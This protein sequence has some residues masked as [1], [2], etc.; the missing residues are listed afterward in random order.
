MARVFSFLSVLA[1]LGVLFVL[2]SCSSSGGS[3]YVST[4]G[5][6]AN[7]GLSPSKPVRTLVKAVRVA[8]T[9]DKAV[10][11]VIKVSG[12]LYTPGNGLSNA[13]VGLVINRPNVIISG[14]WNSDFTS[15]IGKSEFDGN[16]SLYHIIK[17]ENVTNVILKNLVIRGGNA[18][19]SNP[20]DG[21]GGVY[22]NNVRYLTIE[23]NVIISDNS[24]NFGGGLLLYVSANNAIS[25]NVYSNSAVYNGGGLYL[26]YSTNN[27]VN[28]S[29]YNNSAS[30][31]GGG[32]F[33]DSST[34]NT[35]SGSVYGNTANYGGG[36]YLY[37]SD[38]FTN[39]GW[40]TNNHANVSGG[41]VYTNDLHPNSYFGDVSGNSPNNFN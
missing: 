28:S 10:N 33:L 17:I 24:A 40:I 37:N 15:V 18:N 21:G 9:I 6:D 38:Y 39:T 22:V 19:G 20:D 1:V 8:N 3:I 30:A 35:I 2:F 4:T 5:N 32:V 26:I 11:V 29:V 31:W 7:D 13:N 23:S 25:A 16:N 41:G 14:G 27:T 36:V 34:S 12:G